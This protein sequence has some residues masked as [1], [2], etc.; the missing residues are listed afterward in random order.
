MASTQLDSQKIISIL[1]TFY[2]NDTDFI[3]LLFENKINFLKHLT[4]WLN[5]H[6]NNKD[7]HSFSNLF[8][9]IS[10]QKLKNKNSNNTSAYIP[11]ELNK[12]NIDDVF[13]IITDCVRNEDFNC[14][15]EKIKNSFPKTDFSE[16]NF[17]SNNDEQYSDNL[18]M[19]F[20]AFALCLK[21]LY[22]YFKDEIKKI[23]IG[24]F[25]HY[26]NDNKILYYDLFSSYLLILFYFFSIEKKRERKVLSLNFLDD[27]DIYECLTFHYIE[28]DSNNNTIP[29]L[30]DFKNF[31]LIEI[32][33]K[34]YEKETLLNIEL[35]ISID[36]SKPLKDEIF[37]LLKN[38]RQ[39][40]NVNIKAINS[41]YLDFNFLD[42]NTFKLEIELLSENN[43]EKLY[44]N[45]NLKSSNEKPQTDIRKTMISS[46]TDKKKNINM[47]MMSFRQTMI[48]DLR[49]GL[50]LD[51]P[52]NRKSLA[53]DIRKSITLTQE[54]KNELVNNFDNYFNQ[55][56]MTQNQKIKCF[57]IKGENICFSECPNFFEKLRQF[58]YYS[59]IN[60]SNSLKITNFD[61]MSNLQSITMHSISLPEFNLYFL[62][63]ECVFE[64]LKQFD[65][66]IYTDETNYYKKPFLKA[67]ESFMMSK[68]VLNVEKF[69]LRINQIL[70]NKQTTQGECKNFFLTK[71]NCFYFINLAMLKLKKCSSFALTNHCDNF[72]VNPLTDTSSQFHMDE[73]EGCETVATKNSLVVSNIVKDD[74][75]YT[76]SDDVNCKI[77]LTYEN[78]DSFIAL[79][80]SIK[81]NK[82][83]R[84]LKQKPILFNLLSFMV[85][86]R[87]R[88]FLVGDYNN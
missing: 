42:I 62:N 69:K 40:K 32:L 12:N 60:V 70:F 59:I 55:R 80:F 29:T 76:N 66:T 65:V 33:K 30:T 86:K 9:G 44:L 8:Y 47:Q 46:P 10:S 63:E 49:K 13:Y 48:P 19:N 39:L 85:K 5:K 23:C 52:F 58:E 45:P 56:E 18:P 72:K 21:F 83:I 11:F 22:E 73:I 15:R 34:I 38:Q 75:E 71:A 84:K 2:P 31:S 61:I 57:L 43:K 6:Y 17:I 74:F 14:F 81:A 87:E 27:E 79:L 28:I 4:Q 24:D 54:E 67:I 16:L 37:Y 25:P 1:S 78:F 26:N 3:S 41:F 68:S 64:H 20:Y 82:K 50:T 36:I 51:D 88:F 53:P 77:D 35:I 7:I